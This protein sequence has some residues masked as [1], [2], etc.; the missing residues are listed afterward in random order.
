[1]NM[2]APSWLSWAVPAASPT[3][4]SASSQNAP[5]GSH[6]FPVGWFQ[7]VNPLMILLL[8]PVFATLWV[9]LAAKG[10]EPSTPVKMGIGMLIAA[11][12]FVVMVFAALQSQS[13]PAGA[14]GKPGIL[15]VSPIWLCMAYLLHTMGELCLSPVGL[16]MVTKV[17]PWKFASLLMGAWFLSN[18]IANTAAGILGGM[19]GR[20]GNAGFILPGQAGFFLLFVIRPT[21]AGVVTVAVSAL[22]K[23]LSHGRL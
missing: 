11:A 7:S 20:I 5:P 9:K 15:L 14:D 16:S 21:I 12:G 6:V 23:K 8:A 18:F 19:I 22:L 1:T 10:R 3:E 2:L 4:I 13:G 17:A